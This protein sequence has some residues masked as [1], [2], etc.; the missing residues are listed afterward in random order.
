MGECP[1]HRLDKYQKPVL[2]CMESEVQI[3]RLSREARIA[4]LTQPPKECTC[5]TLNL[6]EKESG[7]V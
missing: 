5:D 4:Q 1:I 6:I 2:V 3:E 7:D